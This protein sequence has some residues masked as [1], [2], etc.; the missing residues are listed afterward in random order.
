MNVVRMFMWS[1]SRDLPSQD[2]FSI[3]RHQLILS[4][5]D[6]QRPSRCQAELIITVGH[7]PFPAQLEH[8]AGH[9]IISSDKMDNQKRRRT[10]SVLA[11]VSEQSGKLP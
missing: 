8:V 5:N 7:Q 1:H 9:F 2:T 10:S 11:L 3:P 4:N 6:G